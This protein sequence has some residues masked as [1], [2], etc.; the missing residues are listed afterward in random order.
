MS[1]QPELYDRSD[2]LATGGG[3]R[4]YAFTT[5]ESAAVYFNTLEG[6]Q[7]GRGN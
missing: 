7:D 6:R 3:D 4:G 1:E 5:D 2:H